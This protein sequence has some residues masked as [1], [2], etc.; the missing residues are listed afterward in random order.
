MYLMYYVHGCTGMIL[1]PLCFDFKD[2]ELWLYDQDAK[3][4]VEKL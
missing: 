4:P 3:M 2:N 1:E